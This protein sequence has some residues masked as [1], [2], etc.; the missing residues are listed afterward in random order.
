[1]DFISKSV[2]LCPP[3]R[4]GYPLVQ[5]VMAT[6][7]SQAHV[8]LHVLA[9]DFSNQ[10]SNKCEYFAD[11][12]RC[13]QKWFMRRDCPLSLWAL[14]NFFGYTPS[15]WSGTPRVFGTVWLPMSVL[16]KAN[17]VQKMWWNTGSRLH[18]RQAR[19]CTVG[20]IN[21]LQLCLTSLSR[22]S[23]RVGSTECW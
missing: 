10:G 4:A 18:N 5:L 9:E 15:Q 8:K 7:Q 22:A 21:T 17:S 13:P 11:E 2:L 14:L 16:T 20:G 1:M 12:F 23:C 6:S 3:Q 19:E